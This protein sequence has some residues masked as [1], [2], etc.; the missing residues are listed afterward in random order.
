MAHIVEQLI[1]ELE[2]S[3]DR[4]TALQILAATLTPLGFCRVDY[5]YVDRP[6]DSLA[7]GPKPISL[8]H[9]NFPRDWDNL[10]KRFST[11]DPI[12]L[13]SLESAIP[14]DLT[15]VRAVRPSTGPEGDAW[16]CL[17]NFGVSVALIVPVHLPQG[18]FSNV[19]IYWDPDR[20][21]EEWKSVMSAYRDTLFVLGHYFCETMDRRFIS[22][23]ANTHSARLTARERE[24]LEWTAR[25]KTNR[26]TAA[27]I[28]RSTATVRFHL[29]NAMRKL[30]A[31]N[32]ASAV[33]SAYSM[34][35]LKPH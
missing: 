31:S 26:E 28:G 6:W 35:W 8:I 14:I 22:K 4:Q 11:H 23:G 27:I 17:D 25:G 10:W 9:H 21:I 19:G 12:Y 1:A 20:P 15:T 16:R 5:G 33:A 13:A 24:C 18:R 34:G 32:R 2:C 3:G 30:G 29:E 7:H